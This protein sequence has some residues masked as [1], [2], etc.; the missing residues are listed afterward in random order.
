V[1][2]GSD[3]TVGVTYYDFRSDTPDPST[4]PTDY[5]IVRSHDGG[6]TFGNEEHVA[7]PF[8]MKAA[9]FAGGFFLG[10]YEGLATIGSTFVPL[11]VQANTGN[12]LNPTDAF[13]TTASP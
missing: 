2:V 12:S 13:E 8:D 10:D 4:L 7:G 9:P 3:G 6:A 1:E 11:F 5:F